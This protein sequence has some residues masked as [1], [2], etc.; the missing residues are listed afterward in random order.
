[1]E[2]FILTRL[3]K[4]VNEQEKRKEVCHTLAGNAKKVYINLW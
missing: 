2:V 1:M 4:I 3:T